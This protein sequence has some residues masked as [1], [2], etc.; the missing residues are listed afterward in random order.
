MPCLFQFSGFCFFLLHDA[1]G[2]RIVTV[3]APLNPGLM[4]QPWITVA[5]SFANAIAPPPTAMTSAVVAA[6]LA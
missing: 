1:P 4:T 2:W 3:P 6:M 5:G